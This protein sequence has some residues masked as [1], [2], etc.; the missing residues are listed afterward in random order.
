MLTFGKMAACTPAQALPMARHMCDPTVGPELAAELAAYGV[1]GPDLASR[2][3]ARLRSDLDPRLATLLEI[4]DGWDCVEAIAALL[5]GRTAR[6]S[7]IPGIEH[8]QPQRSLAEALG[9]EAGRLPTRIEISHVAA[10]LKAD[11]AAPLPSLAPAKRMF[12]L[13]GLMGDRMPNEAEQASMAGGRRSDGDVLRRGV[14]G[15]LS[16]RQGAGVSALL[17]SFN[18]PK[19]LSVGVALAPGAERAIL[20]AAHR[21]AA[22][23]AMEEVDRVTGHVRRGD[24]GILELPASSCW[25]SLTHFTA[26]PTFANKATAAE[27]LAAGDPHVHEQVLLLTAALAED[28]R[29]G[30]IDIGSLQHHVKTLGA[31]YQMLLAGELRRAGVAVSLHPDQDCVRLNGVPEDL[32]RLFAKRTVQGEEKAM[33]F[34]LRQ[35]FDLDSA[36]WPL[37][38]ALLKGAVQGDPRSPRRDDVGDLASW[39]AQAAA[40]GARLPAVVP[41]DPSARN[42]DGGPVVDAHALAT[43]RLAAVAPRR[44]MSARTAAALALVEVADATSSDIDRLAASLARPCDGAAVFPATRPLDGAALLAKAANGSAVLVAGGRKGVVAAAANLWIARRSSHGS[45]TPVQVAR[46][47]DVREV[48]DAVRA[49]LRARGAIGPDRKVVSVPDG[50]G[51]QRRIPLA[52]GETIAFTAHV[53]G[54]VDGKGGRV[55]S[56]GSTVLVNAVDEV[57]LSV[58]T[59]RGAPAFIRWPSLFDPASKSMSLAYG[60]AARWPCRADATSVAAILEGS[61]QASRLGLPSTATSSSTATP[62]SRRKRQPCDGSKMHGGPTTDGSG[63]RSPCGWR[64]VRGS[65]SSNASRPHAATPCASGWP[66]RSRRSAAER[67][68]ISRRRHT[69]GPSPR[70]S[71]LSKRSWRRAVPRSRGCRQSRREKTGCGV[72]KSEAKQKHSAPKG[73]SV[74]MGARPPGRR[75]RSARGRRSG[76][77]PKDPARPIPPCAWPSPFRRSAR[78]IS[79]REGTPSTTRPWWRRSPAPAHRPSSGSRGC[80]APSASCGAR[81][82]GRRSGTF[83]S[84]WKRSSP[85]RTACWTS[86]PGERRDRPSSRSEHRRRAHRSKL[87]PSRNFTSEPA[88]I[89][90]RRNGGAHA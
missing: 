87:T 29:A 77:A 79:R 42:I 1:E 21:S 47:E 19:S 41:S 14:V 78:S 56:V 2:S 7:Q 50:V 70:P 3:V 76:L 58:T 11:G 36:G 23:R 64:G 54:V 39:H 34:A 51:G 38:T 4:G 43:A 30:K 90:N 33:A 35:G 13:F 83:S 75:R 46:M 17:L 9:L 18:A 61:A 59:A 37:R 57:G 15:E 32:V 62:K 8:A 73:K 48:E 26:R 65:P 25:I 74:R 45:A 86:Q 40:I 20:L 68:P 49:R 12:K 6:G 5:A 10:G 66:Q 53:N 16:R 60:Y 71:R 82:S 80:G 28:G 72:V 88:T 24:G 44:F 55:G 67:R 81:R 63:T 85:R 52:P 27:G 69:D 31:T 22:S 84:A 89:A